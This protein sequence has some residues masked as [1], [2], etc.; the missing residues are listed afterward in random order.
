MMMMMNYDDDEFMRMMM[1]MIIMIMIMRVT[2][3]LMKMLTLSVLNLPHQIDILYSIFELANGV[4]GLRAL[5]PPS[6]IVEVSD[7][8]DDDDEYSDNNDDD[9]SDDVLGYIQDK[10][11]GSPVSCWHWR[12]LCRGIIII[13]IMIII[14]IARPR[15]AFGWLGLGGSS[16]S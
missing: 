1:M 2:M 15:S 7:Q 9:N 16:G 11:L 10:D 13:M 14:I 4:R 8:G 5:Q 12:A 6:A 3:P